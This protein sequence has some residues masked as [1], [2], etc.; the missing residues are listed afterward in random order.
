MSLRIYRLLVLLCLFQPA[1][2]SGDKRTEPSPAE[3]EKTYVKGSFGYD[4]DFLKT[5]DSVIVLGFSDG[6]YSG[7]Y[8]AALYPGEIKKLVAIG[9]GEWKKGF[10]KFDNSRQGLFSLDSGYFSQQ[11]YWFRNPQFVADLEK[12]KIEWSVKKSV[13]QHQG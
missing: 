1:C 3:S 2:K 13:Y 11:R 7:Y 12:A 4:L 5:K 10:R 8:L 6:A 9:A